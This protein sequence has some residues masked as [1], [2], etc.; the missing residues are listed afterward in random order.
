MRASKAFIVQLDIFSF[1]GTNVR[2]I[3]WLSFSPSQEEIPWQVLSNQK[4]S[5]FDSIVADEIYRNTLVPHFGGEDL[6][7]V[8]SSLG[9]LVVLQQ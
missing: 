7:R 5:L 1:N 8:F 4:L 6:W 3:L 2:G 9:R